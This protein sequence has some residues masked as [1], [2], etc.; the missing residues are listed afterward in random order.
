VLV[1]TERIVVST[2]SG[3]TEG[4]EFAL[5]LDSP[6]AAREARLMAK[7]GIEAVLDHATISHM[8]AEHVKQPEPAREEKTGQCGS[9]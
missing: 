4:L 6:K 9:I 3:R 8:V 1:R 5:E 2:A 7:I